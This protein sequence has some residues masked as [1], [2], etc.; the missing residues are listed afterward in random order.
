MLDGRSTEENHLKHFSSSFLAPR[1][2]QN[3]EVLYKN[4]TLE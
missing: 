3:I 4:S 1:E 2:P